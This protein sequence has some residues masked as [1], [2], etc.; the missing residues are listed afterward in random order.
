MELN[1]NIDIAK[2]Y[3]SSSQKIRV[4]TESWVDE[5]IYCPNCGVRI[6]NY[7]NNKPVADFYCPKCTEDFELKSKRNSIGKKLMDGA[8]R[9]MIKRLDSSTNPN[10]FLLNYDHKNFNI[11]NFLVI[12][13]HFFTPQIIEKRKPLAETAKRAGWIGCNILID[14]IPQSGRIFYIE[15]FKLKPKSEVTEQWERTLFLK[16]DSTFE[17]KSWVIDVMKCIDKLG[18][19]EFTLSEVYDCA[20]VLQQLHP[21]NHHIKA[22][23]R[24]QLQILR[25]ND[26]LKFTGKGNYKLSSHT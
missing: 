24:Q 17:S 1:L 16:K 26:Y 13:K 20:D 22:K 10:F 19:S 4:M 6:I 3:K 15:N 5:N 14:Q 21:E 12:P 8:F 2:S 23:I 11:I 9:T 18:K 7:E 25:D